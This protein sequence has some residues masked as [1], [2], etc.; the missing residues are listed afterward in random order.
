MVCDLGTC[1]LRTQVSQLA[2]F[3]YTKQPAARK[4]FQPLLTLIRIQA[5][6]K[7]RKVRFLLS[8][9]LLHSFSLD[10]GCGQSSA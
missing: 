3:A 6:A 5:R 10:P 9:S 1:S 7:E 2:Y 4:N 8:N